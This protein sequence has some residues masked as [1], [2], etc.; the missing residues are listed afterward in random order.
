MMKLAQQN[1]FSYPMNELEKRVDDL[2]KTIFK[3]EIKENKIE[4]NDDISL[5]NDL[6]LD[7]LKVMETVMECENNLGIKIKNIEIVRCRTYGNIKDL[8]VK[9]LKEKS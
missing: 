2:L 5:L 6:G 9:K 1:N 4:I 3:S 7:S 8:L